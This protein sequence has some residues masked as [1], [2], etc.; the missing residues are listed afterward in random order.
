MTIYYPEEAKSCTLEIILFENA[1]S[2]T[3]KA[4]MRGFFAAAYTKNIKN[5]SNI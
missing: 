4:A 2:K 1:Q 5:M 3:K